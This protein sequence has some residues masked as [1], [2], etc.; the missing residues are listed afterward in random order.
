MRDLNFELKQ[1]CHANRDGSYR[2]QADRERTLA[3]IANQ[4]H[5]L[6]YRNPSVA[7]R[8]GCLANSCGFQR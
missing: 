8:S 5:A 4:L 1:L 3:Q 6:G 2:T 7:K